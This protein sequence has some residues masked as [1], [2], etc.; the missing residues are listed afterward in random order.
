MDDPKISDE[1]RNMEHEP[2]LPIERKLVA[3]SI[4]T[5]VVLL[6]VL[7]LVSRYF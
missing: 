2:I 1:L 6:A 7:V 3:W 5:G 4:G